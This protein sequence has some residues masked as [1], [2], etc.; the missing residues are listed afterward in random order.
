MPRIRI[1]SD[2]ADAVWSGVSTV[3]SIK[4]G[5]TQKKHAL[6]IVLLPD[7]MLAISRIARAHLPQTPELESEAIEPARTFSMAV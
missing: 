1:I 7:H 4:L 6:R 3:V 2:V 5:A